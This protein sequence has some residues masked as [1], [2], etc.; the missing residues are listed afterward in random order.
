MADVVNQLVESSGITSYLKTSN[1]VGLFVK[2]FLVCY[3]AVIAPSLPQLFKPL[4]DN[5]YLKVVFFF[6][7]AYLTQ[8]DPSTALLVAL[9]FVIS[10]MYLG[11]NERKKLLSAVERFQDTNMQVAQEGNAC[12]SPTG[13]P[14][15][16]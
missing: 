6:V 15:C 3:A 14:K 9:A 7:L 11:V 4:A 5:V 10:I 2:V 16:A 12:G 1:P 13:G 8:S